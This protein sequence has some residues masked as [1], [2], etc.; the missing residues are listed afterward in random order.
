MDTQHL[1]LARLNRI[2]EID[3][4][5]AIAMAM[6]YLFHAW[7]FGGC[8]S[9]KLSFLGREFNLLGFLGHF[10]TGVD[11]F[12]V[13]SGFCLFLPVCKSQSNLDGWDWRDYAKRRVFRIVPPYYAAIVYTVLV[14][15]VL[16]ALFHALKLPGKW[17]PVPS[18]WQFVTH[19]LFIHTMFPATWNGITGAFWSLGLEG[20]FYLVFPFVV[21][22]FRNAGLKT[23]AVMILSS[24]LFRMVVEEWVFADDWRFI[25]SISFLGRWM[26]FGFGML[27][28]VLVTRYWRSGRQLHWGWGVLQVMSA[29]VLYVF[30]MEAVLPSFLDLLPLRDLMI[31]AAFA[32]L[33]HALCTSDTWLVIPFQNR[34]LCR[35]GFISYSL[36]LLHQPTAWYLSEFFK[37]QMH[38]DGI[39]DFYLLCTVGFAVLLGIALPFFHVFERP[40]VAMARKEKS[41]VAPEPDGSAEYSAELYLERGVPGRESLPITLPGQ[42]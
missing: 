16:V 41:S 25:L 10:T 28:A 37:K 35:L 22:A 4:V 26:Q 38:L 13:I 20:Q 42:L 14:P 32:L 23:I 12:M 19:L 30:T 24:I 21:F 8:P 6:V 40:F 3:G 18:V 27:A 33:I 17:Q 36:F 11:F 5:R 2:P 34:F 39:T 31:S 29:A 7:Q 9:I 15:I 1:R